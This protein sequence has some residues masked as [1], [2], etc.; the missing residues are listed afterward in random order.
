MTDTTPETPV[1]TEAPQPE[2]AAEPTVEEREDAYLMEIDGDDPD[3][4]PA[5]VE[6]A[7]EESAPAEE[8]APEA[9]PETTSDIDTDELEEGLERPATRRVL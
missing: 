7:A 6:E 4:L 5:P 9:E 2:V 3:E 8:A 1:V